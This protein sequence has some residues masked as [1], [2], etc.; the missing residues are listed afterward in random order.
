MSDGCWAGTTAGNAPDEAWVKEESWPLATYTADAE[1]NFNQQP[2]LKLRLKE[3]RKGEEKESIPVSLG[4]LLPP[5]T[6]HTLCILYA[7]MIAGASALQLSSEKWY[8][9]GTTVI[10]MIQMMIIDIKQQLSGKVGLEMD[11]RITLCSIG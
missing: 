9:E 2:W 4:P 5:A 1:L 8:E 10:L 6:A 7:K 11:T 3:W